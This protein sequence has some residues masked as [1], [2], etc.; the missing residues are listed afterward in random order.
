LNNTTTAR[1]R[2]RLLD[3]IAR[4]RA[5][6]R[7]QCD[8]ILGFLLPQ[9][10]NDGIPAGLPEGIRVAHKTGDITGVAHDAAIVFPAK[11]GALCAGDLDEGIR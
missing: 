2:A 7:V 4:N 11:E 3:A 8:T 10:F 5:A 6:S 9:E 1:D